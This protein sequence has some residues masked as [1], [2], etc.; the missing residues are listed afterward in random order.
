MVTTNFKV[1]DELEFHVYGSQV[2]KGAYISETN[3]AIVIKITED[4]M[5]HV[6]KEQA[7]SKL[8][9]ITK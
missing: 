1:G 3:D 8:F 5:G 6:G 7:I 4:D 2:V 9:L